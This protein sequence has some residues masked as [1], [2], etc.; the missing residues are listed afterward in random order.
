M[1]II[2]AQWICKIKDIM[3]VP[4]WKDNKSC[5]FLRKV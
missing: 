1:K 4:V 5:N 3:H 2:E